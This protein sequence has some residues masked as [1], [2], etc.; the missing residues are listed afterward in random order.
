MF[1]LLIANLWTEGWISKE[2][3]SYIASFLNVESSYLHS[4]QRIAKAEQGYWRLYTNALLKICSYSI[5][6]FKHSVSIFLFILNWTN[7]VPTSCGM[8]SAL[9]ASLS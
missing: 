5:F 4:N 7:T 6:F 8:L 3:A 2:V 1:N 9:V